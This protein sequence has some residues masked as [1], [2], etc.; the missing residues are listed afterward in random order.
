[1]QIDDE[2]NNLKSEIITSMAKVED[3]HHRIVL[4]LLIRTMNSQE[5]FSNKIFEK[6]ELIIRDEERIKEIVL[7]GHVHEHKRHHDWVEERMLY[8]EREKVDELVRWATRKMETEKEFTKD[9]R[10]YI[11]VVGEKLL[12]AGLL[13][14]LGAIGAVIWAYLHIE[15]VT[16]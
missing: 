8:T 4:S 15:P 6:L 10:H 5:S 2:L 3:G 1:M 11:R 16:K 12:Y 13:L 7:N 14:L 9:N